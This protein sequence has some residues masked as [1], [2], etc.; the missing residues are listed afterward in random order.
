M[1]IL[2]FS[3][4]ISCCCFCWNFLCTP[5]ENNRLNYTSY[6]KIVYLHHVHNFI[7][8]LNWNSVRTNHLKFPCETLSREFRELLERT[9]SSPFASL[10]L[11]FLFCFCM[12]LIVNLLLCTQAK[13]NVNWNPVVLK[14]WFDYFYFESINGIE[15]V[16]FSFR[17]LIN[18]NS[19]SSRL[20]LMFLSSDK[21]ISFNG[22]DDWP[23]KIEI[24][25]M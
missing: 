6:T 17:Y 21:S 16:I 3:F 25:T 18:L 2:F 22:I 8:C 11:F 7:V 19:D 9:Q 13:E 24:E 12:L 20:L 1:S 14:C 23:E 5:T 10:F 15:M 4:R